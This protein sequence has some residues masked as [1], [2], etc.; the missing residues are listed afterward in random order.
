LVERIIENMGS[1]PWEEVSQRIA[2]LPGIRRDKVLSVRRQITEGT[3]E[4]E[5]RLDGAIDR[6]LDALACPS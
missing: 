1:T 4:V 5:D 6:V 2:F 3:Y